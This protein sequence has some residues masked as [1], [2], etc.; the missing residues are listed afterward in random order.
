MAMMLRQSF[1]FD[2]EAALIEKAIPAVWQDGWRTPDLVEPGTRVI[3]TNEMAQRIADKVKVI[4]SEQ[5]T[6]GNGTKGSA[7]RTRAAH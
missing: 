5:A 1:G 7:A 4:A 6:A 2:H 3:G